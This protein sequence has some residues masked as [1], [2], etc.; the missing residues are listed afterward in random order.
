MERRAQIVSLRWAGFGAKCHHERS[1]SIENA[2]AARRI[3]SFGDN[4]LVEG[5]R[6]T[7]TACR[8]AMKSDQPGNE[9]LALRAAVLAGNDA[10]WQV[11]YDRH[12]DALYAF[13]WYRS[14]RRADRAEEVVQETWLAAVRRIEAFDPALGAFESWL[15]GIAANVLRNQR[16][17]WRREEQA[18]ALCD[19]NLLQEPA[20]PE[21]GELVGLALTALPQRYQAVL[22][23]KYEERLSV[24][25]IAGRLGVTA[26]AA[27]SL[28]SRARD[29]FRDAFDELTPRDPLP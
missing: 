16:R 22:R 24:A 21:N 11:L 4:K 8:A 19:E 25:E 26:K 15:K 5:G 2:A 20:P 14:G 3:F 23:A 18:E 17:R 9:E 12:V 29:A 7:R 28:L 13:A 1:E 10:A 27:E 6:I